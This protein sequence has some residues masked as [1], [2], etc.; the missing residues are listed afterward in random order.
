MPVEAR[1]VEVRDAV[2]TE[3]AERVSQRFDRAGPH[4][5]GFSRLREMRTL[6]LDGH[7]GPFFKSGHMNI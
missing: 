2:R 4:Q 5:S 3:D 7:G 6:T 1:E